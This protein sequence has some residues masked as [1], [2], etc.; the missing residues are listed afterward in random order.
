M[1]AAYHPAGRKHWIV[2]RGGHARGETGQDWRSGRHGGQ[3]LVAVGRAAR[4]ISCGHL[5]AGRGNSLFK[6]VRDVTPRDWL[7]SMLSVGA[8]E[9][10]APARAAG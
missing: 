1:A 5:A 8:S 2:A 4:A 7:A 10:A 9:R 6:E 3:V